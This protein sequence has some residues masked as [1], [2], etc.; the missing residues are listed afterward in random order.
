MATIIMIQGER[1]AGKTATAGLVY[2]KLLYITGQPHLFY[3]LHAGDTLAI[4]LDPANQDSLRFLPN[5]TIDDFMAQFDIFGKQVGIISFG[6][7]YND[8]RP[9]LDYFINANVDIILCCGSRLSKQGYKSVDKT[10][11]Q[12]YNPDYIF[13]LGRVICQPNCKYGDFT[14]SETRQMRNP[15]AE[16]IIYLILDIIQSIY[17]SIRNKLHSYGSKNPFNQPRGH[18]YR[19]HYNKQATYNKKRQP[20]I[21]TNP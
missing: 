13:E 11:R 6:D 16:H 9:A 3:N 5:G 1:S 7:V 14:P 17:Q 4:K 2:Q 19:K 21:S 15:I 8:T 20:Y 10:I 18:V 12:N